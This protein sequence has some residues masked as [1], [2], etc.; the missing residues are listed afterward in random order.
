MKKLMKHKKIE[1]HCFSWLRR[2]SIKMCIP[3][4]PIYRFSAVYTTDLVKRIIKFLLTH[5][6][7]HT[8][9]GKKSKTLVDKTILSKQNKAGGIIL[10]DFK[11]YYKTVAIKNSMVLAY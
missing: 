11:I 3:P 8:Q 7:T 1:K 10:S 4:K 5:T 2:I 6:H 9:T